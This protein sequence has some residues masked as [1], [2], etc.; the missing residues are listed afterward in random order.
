MNR[1]ELK[2]RIGEPCIVVGAISNWLQNDDKGAFAVCLKDCKIA[3]YGWSEVTDHL[4]VYIDLDVWKKKKGA[5]GKIKTGRIVGSLGRV[6][7]YRRSDGSYDIGVKEDAGLMKLST[8]IKTRNKIS[9]EERLRLHEHKLIISDS[10]D[11]LSQGS[12]RFNELMRRDRIEV[13][14]RMGKQKNANF[15]PTKIAQVKRTKSNGFGTR[16]LEKNGD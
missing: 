9:L 7:R 6:G 16:L 2:D 1:T 11:A 12:E 10:D 3:G 8:Y 4:W 5:F 15:V 13:E 14:R